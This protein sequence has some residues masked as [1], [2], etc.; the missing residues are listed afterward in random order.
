MVSVSL[1]LAMF[2]GLTG[3][4]S[5][6]ERIETQTLQ[7]QMGDYSSAYA[8]AAEAATG[9][10]VDTPFWSAEAGALALMAGTPAAAIPHLDAADNGFNDVARLFQ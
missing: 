6:R 3:C 9:D 4:L 7:V 10:D 2:A 1:G 5:V 8:A